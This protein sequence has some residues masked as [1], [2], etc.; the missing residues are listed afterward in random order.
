MFLGIL[1][2][3]L[4]QKFAL[5]LDPNPS[6][7]WSCQ[8][9]TDN[10][11]EKLPC[12]V[13]AGSSHSSRLIDPLES[14]HFTVVDST[15][16]GF[17]ITENSVA[18]MTADIEEKIAELDPSSTVVLIQLLDNSIYQCTLPNGDRILPRKGRDGK[19]HA[20]GELHVVNRD[21]VRELFSTLQPLFRAVREFKCIVMTPL[22]RYL[23][24]RCCDNPSHITNSEV[25]GYAA[26]MGASLRELNKCLRNMIFMRKLKGISTLN[27]MEALG[28]I[29][30][31]VSDLN[32]DEDRVI[33]LWGPDPVH[34]TSAAYRELATRVAEKTMEILSEKS[35][36]EE[37]RANTKR[38]ADPRDPW[39]EQS[40]AIAKRLDERGTERGR[41]RG[42]GGTG[43][44]GARPPHRPFKG[45]GW[46]HRGQRRGV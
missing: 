21:T 39:I 34:P 3:E 14:A 30:S 13:L 33:A 42:R 5:R 9:A 29:P 43:Y 6:T 22:P 1:L 27:A 2:E 25:S 19:Y 24:A 18:E 45:R 32:E 41:G 11:H 7:D 28:L 20:E 16:A 23:W 36:Q 8:S 10:Q 4:N 38:K 26:A 31:S 37:Q 17:R 12:I 46:W 40:Q 44:R 35:P 15:V